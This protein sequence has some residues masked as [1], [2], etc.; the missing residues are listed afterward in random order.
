MN[1]RTLNHW[2]TLVA[3]IGVLAGILFLAFEIQQNTLATKLDA[4]TMFQTSYSEIEVSIYGDPEFAALLVKGREDRPVDEIESLR[5]QVFHNNVMR[6]WQTNH[7]LYLAG[8]LDEDIWT[9]NREFMKLVLG[10]NIGL[11][12]HWQSS[13]RLYSPAFNEMLESISADVPPAN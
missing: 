12:R 13:K 1:L 10:D 6:H 2:L 3:N 4:A 11:R 8:A 5:L 7:L 9:G